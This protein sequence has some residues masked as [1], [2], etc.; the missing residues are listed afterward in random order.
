MYRRQLLRMAAAACGLGIGLRSTSATEQ[1]VRL[2]MPFAA[3]GGPDLLARNA[4]PE[5]ACA[6][7]TPVVVDNRPGA[8]GTVAAELAMRAAPDGHTLFVGTSAHVVNQLML[9]A[10]RFDVLADFTPVS[11]MWQS[12]AVL[13]V[14]GASP[15][16][17]VE[18]LVNRLRAEPGKA[19]Y[20]SGGVGTAAHLAGGAFV[21]VLGLDAVHVP[22]RGSVDVPAALSSGDALFAIPVASAV[23]PAVRDGRLR[24]LAVTGSTRLAQLP[25]VPTL[26]ERFG[27]ELLVQLS[28][29]GLWLPA[30][31]GAALVER[32]HRANATAM[33]VPAVRRFHEDSGTEA[34][35]SASP[36]EFQAFMQAEQRKWRQ[37]LAVLD[38]LPARPTGAAPAPEVGRA[39]AR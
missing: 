8:G 3:G 5:L 13:V 27:S 6:L 20:A 24:A 25:D 10:A 15:L 9:P 39:A 34:I 2:L 16:R 37:V 23:L 7:G 38:L 31:A 22:Y 19:N 12:P 35:V 28:W 17:S 30:G 26:H 29:G 14:S 11:L 36:A 33:Q 1:T 18:A 32:I 4:A 21:K